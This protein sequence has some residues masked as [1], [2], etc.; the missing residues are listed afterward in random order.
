MHI[1]LPGRHYVNLSHSQA[2][3]S[4]QKVFQVCPYFVF[5]GLFLEEMVGASAASPGCLYRLEL[6]W[7]RLFLVNQQGFFRLAGH[8]RKI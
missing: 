1:H 5:S 3:V 8:C 6:H 7:D 4:E 2:F